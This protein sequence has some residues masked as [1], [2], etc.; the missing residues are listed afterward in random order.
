ML[1]AEGFAL[2]QQL[3]HAANT[4]LDCA[5]TQAWTLK[6]G[7]R[8]AGAAC[9]QH[10]SSVSALPEGWA[11]FSAGKFTAATFHTRIEGH[12]LAFGFVVEHAS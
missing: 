8:K 1:G 2:A 9:T 4:P 5:A 3:S 12:S 6:E 7:L 11:C 10:V